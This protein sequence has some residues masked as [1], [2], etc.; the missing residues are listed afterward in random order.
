VALG[1]GAFLSYKV[2]ST[3]AGVNEI[4][5]GRK[6]VEAGE[7][8]GRDREGARYELLQWISYAVGLSAVAV[9]ATTFYLGGSRGEPETRVAI[10]PG[11]GPGQ[12]GAAIQGAF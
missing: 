11:V 12:V 1:V 7:L 2:Q 6:L 5:K 3:E 8:K 4:I 10:V 9:G